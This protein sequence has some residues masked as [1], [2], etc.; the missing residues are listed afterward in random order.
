MF[1]VAKVRLYPGQVV[2][3]LSAEDLKTVNT[4]RLL[5]ANIVPG[6]APDVVSDTWY[7]GSEADLRAGDFANAISYNTG[8]AFEVDYFP[9][10]SGQIFATAASSGAAIPNIYVELRFAVWPE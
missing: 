6:E 4:L 3:L 8:E 2:G 10:L 7:L 9:R 1:H 5:S